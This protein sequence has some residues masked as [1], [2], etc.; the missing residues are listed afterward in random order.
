MVRRVAPKVDCLWCSS[1]ILPSRVWS[2][3]YGRPSES[4]R[5]SCQPPCFPPGFPQCFRGP[6]ARSRLRHWPS[7]RSPWQSPWAILPPNLSPQASASRRWRAYR[8][9]EK[10]H[11]GSTRDRSSP[12]IDEKAPE[13]RSGANRSRLPADDAAPGSRAAA[14]PG[15]RGAGRPRR[16]SAP[17]RPRPALRGHQSLIRGPAAA[18]GF[19]PRGGSLQIEPKLDGDQRA[20]HQAMRGCVSLPPAA[21]DGARRPRAAPRCWPGRVSWPLREV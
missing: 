2:H 20:S 3:E 14:G 17:A 19:C 4:V 13:T 11:L 15:F 10:G 1:L 7:S 16:R 21:P 6:A 12:S 8:G 9:M 5:H 18:P